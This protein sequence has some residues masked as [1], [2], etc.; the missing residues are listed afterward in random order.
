MS[1]M[2]L[3]MVAIPVQ[4]QHEFVTGATA[5][6]LKWQGP[7]FSEL[8]KAVLGGTELSESTLKASQYISISEFVKIMIMLKRNHIRSYDY[9]NTEAAHWSIPYTFTCQH[10]Y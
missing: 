6:L 10:D 2:K 8:L 5:T 9:F 3:I 7:A 1:K 4:H